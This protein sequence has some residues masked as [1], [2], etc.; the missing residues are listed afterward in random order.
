MIARVK[1]FL[2][3]VKT[4]LGKASWPWDPKEKGFKRYREL[5]D[6]TLVVIFGIIFLGAFV[7]LTEVVLASVAGMATRSGYETRAEAAVREGNAETETDAKK[8][9]SKS[10]VI[11]VQPEAANSASPVPGPT[12]ATNPAATTGSA[13]VGTASPSST[14]ATSG[15]SGVESTKENK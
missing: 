9:A 13:S 14:P 7:S 5:Y 12:S 15:T 8:A 11:P 1:K 2:G 10:K 4:E 6:S 3:E